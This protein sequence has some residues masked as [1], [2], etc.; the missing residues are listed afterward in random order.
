MYILYN[1]LFKKGK[2]GDLRRL[3]HICELF[4]KPGSVVDSHLSSRRVAAAIKPPRRRSG[5]PYVPIAVLLRIEFTAMGTLEPSG[6]LLPHLSTLTSSVQTSY[7]SSRCKQQAELIPLH[8]LSPQKRCFCGDPI[9]G[10]EAVYLCCTFPEVAF[11]GRYP[12]SSPCG[13]RTFLIGRLSPLPPRLSEHLAR[14]FYK[15]TATMSTKTPHFAEY[16]IYATS[17]P[18]NIVVG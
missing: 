16:V 7:H 4:C 2:D 11:G 17:K 15:T 6:E 5:Q 8:L 9:S 12:L 13:A 18:Q 14:L 3:F 10:C 1:T